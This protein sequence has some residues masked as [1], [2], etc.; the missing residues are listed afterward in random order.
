MQLRVA[1]LA[2]LAMKR[3]A[4]GAVTGQL[5]KHLVPDAGMADLV[6]G[7]RAEGNVLFEHR[8]DAGPLRVAET[9]HELV[10][11]HRQQQTGQRVAR[12]WLERPPVELRDVRL[13]QLARRESGFGGHLSVFSAARSFALVLATS[14]LSRIT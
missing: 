8:R 3:Q 13:D 2:R 4:V 12:L 11:G 7:N 5:G 9:D 14:S 1:V 10:V 6:L